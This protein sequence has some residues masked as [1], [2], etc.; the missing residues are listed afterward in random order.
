MSIHPI[1]STV[2]YEGRAQHDVLR[3]LVDDEVSR[4]VDVRIRAQS[5]KPGFSKTSLA[6]GL[7]EVGIEYEHLRDLGTPLDIR[8]RFRA[9]E[10][11]EA[12][13]EYR[14]YLRGD[15]AARLALETLAQRV[16][17]E[18][19]AI[20]CFEHD[21]RVCHRAVIAEELAASHGVVARHL[22]AP[23]VT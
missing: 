2:G 18:H 8:A 9:K 17:Q 4:L 5:R 11:E 20:L 21:H 3:L 19:V 23:Q 12:R 14:A 1:M 6:A 16:A 7:A 10:T 13:E 15:L 22:G